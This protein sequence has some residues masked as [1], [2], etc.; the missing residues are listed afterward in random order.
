VAA[1]ALVAAALSYVRLPQ[2][3]PGGARVAAGVVA[4]LIA[5]A[6]IA[7]ATVNF[8][9]RY[10]TDTSAYY[11]DVIRFLYAST[12][13]P[14]DGRPVYSGPHMRAGMLAGDRLEHRLHLL[15]PDVDCATVRALSRTAYLLT[16]TQPLEAGG[17]RVARCLAGVPA[18]F[19]GTGYRLDAPR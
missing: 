5:G 18:T 16:I 14:D 11:T 6:C 17:Q 1:G 2:R 8:T 19:T 7:G 4:L 9:Q 10:A 3:I 13:F 12:T 15:P